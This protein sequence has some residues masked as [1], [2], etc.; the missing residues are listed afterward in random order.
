M[1]NRSKI[2]VIKNDDIQFIDEHARQHNDG[3]LTTSNGLYFKRQLEFVF[4]ETLQASIPA[5]NAFRFFPISAEVGEGF[6]EYTQR[7]M[8][9]VGEAVII[10]NFADDLPRV[11]MAMKEITMAIKMLGDAYCSSG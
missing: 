1:S 8:E 2:K 10:S 5:P 7:L 6:K 9:P 4:A 11:N 3:V